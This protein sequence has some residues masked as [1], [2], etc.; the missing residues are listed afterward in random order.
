LAYTDKNAG[1]A[2][3]TVSLNAVTLDDGNGGNN[4]TVTLAGN[5]TSTINP[6]NVTLAAPV[7][8]KTYDGGLAYTTTA[9]DLTAM[10]RGL[11][12][13]DKVAAATLAYTDR[14]VG[15]ANKTVNLNAVTI[16]DGNGGNNYIVTRA[17]SNSGTIT[18]APLATWVG[19][20]TGQ[21]S[22]ASNWTALPDGNNVL[23]VSIPTGTTVS[24]DSGVAATTLQSL[25]SLGTLA[26]TGSNLA[27]VNSLNTFNYSQSGGT[28]SGAGTFTVSN[29]FSQSAGTIAMGGAVSI[30]QTSGDLSVGS[31]SGSSIA[32]EAVS[33]AIS[34]TAPLATVGLLKVAASKGVTLTN[35]GNAV[36]AFSAI[37]TGTGDVALTNVGALDVQE[38]TVADGKLVLDNTGAVT[39]NGVITV[40]TGGLDATAHS[41][42]TV[43]NTI[44]ADGGIKLTALNPEPS[45]NI[46]INGNLSSSAGGIS[47]AAYNS[48]IQ[49]AN[50]KAAL[51]IDVKASAVTFGPSALSIGNPVSY[52][53]NGAPYLPP[54]I[55]STVSGGANDFVA[56]FLDKFQ[57]AM[58]AQVASI[59]DPLGAKKR[60]KEGLVVEGET[61]KP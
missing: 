52:A 39:T 44:T 48:F 29:S 33:G 23:A 22:T 57:A 10:G 19:G 38:I 56:T 6:A 27:V 59:D 61:C 32:L 40:H 15:T 16:D 34:Q 14:N 5:S 37:T 50:L 8:S 3:K 21:W 47:V 17:A 7:V 51:A 43:N 28:V 13:S 42:I 58:D 12:G 30:H 25:T 54:W 53:V 36:S 20:S 18:P 31:I 1:T 9:A 45:S 11:I 41:P 49:N 60:S 55:A 4:Y 26:F 24:F 35:A 2:N 46:T